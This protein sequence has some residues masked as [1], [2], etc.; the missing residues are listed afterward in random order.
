MLGDIGIWD[1]GNEGGTQEMNDDITQV[2]NMDTNV[3]TV[4]KDNMSA[5]KN[6]GTIVFWVGMLIVYLLYD[7]LQN[8]KLKDTLEPHNIRANIHNLLVVTIAAVIGING[9]NVLLTKLAAMQIP[10]ASK[11]AGTIL[12]LFHL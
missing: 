5:A 4:V 11:G 2:S 9:G 12:P 3:G 10:G 8:E 1:T 6:P 7:W